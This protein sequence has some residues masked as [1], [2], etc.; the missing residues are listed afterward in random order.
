MNKELELLNKDV[1]GV[2]YEEYKEYEVIETIITGEWRHGAEKTTIIKS[3]ISGK[4]YQSNYREQ[5]DGM[6][7]FSNVNWTDKHNFFE[8]VPEEKTITVYRRVKK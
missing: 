7:G 2:I 3:K 1:G 6:E 5:T 4:F 8:V